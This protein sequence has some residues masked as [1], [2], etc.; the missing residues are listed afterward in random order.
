MHDFRLPED[1]QNFPE[2]EN[3]ALQ[4]KFRKPGEETGRSLTNLAAKLAKEQFWLFL[5]EAYEVSH[6]SV[7]D[8]EITQ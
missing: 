4:R 1:S 2:A 7:S 8:L 5:R 6:L 3:V